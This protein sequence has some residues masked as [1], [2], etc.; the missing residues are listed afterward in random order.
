MIRR[1]IKKVTPILIWRVMRKMYYVY[2]TFRYRVIGRPYVL[3]ETTKAHKRRIKEGFFDKYCRGKGI[4]IGY[5]GD[6]IVGGCFGWDFEHGDAQ[7][8]QSV[9]D[10]SFSFVY[11]SH[12]LEHMIDPSTAL[13]NWW[14]I[15]KPEG[16]L[17][18][19]VPHRE[20]YEK[21]TTLPSNWNPDHKHFFLLDRDEKPHTI[22]L[23]PLLQRT[24]SGY[25]IIY[26]KVC[27][28]NNTISDPN[29]H[30]D[31]EYS[32]ELVLKKL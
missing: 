32:M 16:F 31:G 9:N 5:G 29:L 8:M 3:A 11:S 20:L 22:G 10:Q 25:E 13:K 27:D 19:Y 7:Y 12:T 15:L 17:I 14:R 23:V 18:L 26:A 4:D 30:S 24:L 6:L 1:F 28:Q 21:K 2:L